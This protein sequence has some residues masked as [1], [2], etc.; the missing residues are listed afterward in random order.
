MKLNK[1]RKSLIICGII[2]DAFMCIGLFIL[3]GPLPEFRNFWITTAMTTMNHQ[4]LAH[5]F[6][7]SKTIDY[8]MSQNYVIAVDEDT[9]ISLVNSDEDIKPVA[10]QDKYEEQVLTKDE[11][12]DLYKVINIDENGCKGYLVVVYDPSKIS[13][14]MTRYLGT[15]GETVLN[16]AK[17]NN[18]RIAINA[19]GFP[20][21]NDV[22]NGSIPTGSV[23]KD[24]EIIYSSPSPGR[25]GGVIGFDYNDNLILS[26]ESMTT[27]LTKYN[28]RDAVE[29]GPFLI[30]N[31]KASFIQG[32]GGWGEAPR[33]VIGQRADGIVLLLIIDGKIRIAGANM[34]ELTKI[35]SDYKAINAANMD[36]GASTG[37]IVENK[38][39]NK[40]AGIGGNGL[41]NIPNAWIVKE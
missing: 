7:S 17:N 23:V 4:Y 29:F 11:G 10:Y 8:V 16:I 31:G 32:N 22:G 6:Y 21:L 1:K 34:V 41:R 28:L 35:M 25:N 38:I 2:L 20:D 26:K 24:G 19:S 40:P 3:Y 9:D 39:A 18:A 36:G 27:A 12:N 15:R 5:I 14:V 13:L 33:T 37:L 30:I